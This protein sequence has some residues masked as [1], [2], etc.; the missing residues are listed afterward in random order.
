MSVILICAIA[1][2]GLYFVMWWPWQDGRIGLYFTLKYFLV[3]AIGVL[4]FAIYS[5]YI[6]PSHESYTVR[7]LGFAIIFAPVVNLFYA[8]LVFNKEYRKS[9]RPNCDSSKNKEP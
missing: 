3:Y 6:N 9:L 8:A 7:L 1:S 5:K 4:F 2:A